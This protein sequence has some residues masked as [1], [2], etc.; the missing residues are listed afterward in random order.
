MAVVERDRGNGSKKALYRAAVFCYTEVTETG[1]G[2]LQEWSCDPY[3]VELFEEEGSREL[4][5]A[6]VQRQSAAELRRLLRGSGV[7]LAAI[8]GVDWDRELSPWRAPGLARNGGDFAGRGPAL[9][10]AL[11]RRIVPLVE[12]RLGF[13]PL[14][15]GIAGYSLAGL[16]ALWSA[17]VTD[18]FDCAASVSGSLWFD[19]ALAFFQSHEPYVR[20]AYLSVGDREKEAKNPRLAAVED[21]TRR[22]AGL[23]REKGVSVS[24]EINR[25]GHFQDAGARL[26]RGIRALAR[27]AAPEPT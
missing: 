25:G 7:S 11:V 14:S 1:A 9:L 2:A 3:T 13:A 27:P 18:A 22:T 5:Y 8:Y 26:A 21:C 23:L 16:F 4:V 20:A 24:L 15:R 12:G 17:F 6:V 19:G 10:D